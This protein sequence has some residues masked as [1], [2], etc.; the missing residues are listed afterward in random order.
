MARKKIVLVIVE[1]PSDASAL[2][3]YFVKYFDS[4][5]IVTKIIH[6]D[7]TTD[8]NIDQ[9]KIKAHLGS[10][11]K[12]WIINDKFKKSDI[13]RIIHIVDMDGAYID[14]SFIQ[15]DESCKDPYYSLIS[16]KTSNVENICNRNAQKRE[17]INTLSTNTRGI[18]NGIP[19]KVYYMSCNLDHVLYN[20]QNA[21]NKEKEEN[22][23]EFSEKYIDNI[24]EF[25]YF[26]CN[27]DF[28]RCS[29]SYEDSWN[30]IKVDKHS[31]ERYSN[32]GLCFSCPD[33]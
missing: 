8:K 4:D 26:L 31:L 33:C 32:L 23:L 30:F 14:D 15:L 19:Y 18:C 1:G 22:A 6:G 24:N 29:E 27:S 16:I 12:S 28:S 13:D 20:L 25:V 5:R 21:N 11:V 3:R 10:K 2:E 7:I 17:N 9:S